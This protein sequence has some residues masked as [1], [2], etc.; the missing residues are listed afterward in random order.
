MPVLLTRLSMFLAWTVS[1][2]ALR[3]GGGRRTCD[4]QLK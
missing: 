2:G 3:I 1:S 4:G